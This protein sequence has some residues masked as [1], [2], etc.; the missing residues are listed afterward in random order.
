ME[1]VFTILGIIAWVVF[2]IVI[3][4]FFGQVIWNWIVPELGGP[5][6]S[7]WQMLKL[8]ILIRVL[9]GAPNSFNKKDK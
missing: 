3:T 8:T 7:M 5:N 9:W 2:L 6:I 4:T 1:N